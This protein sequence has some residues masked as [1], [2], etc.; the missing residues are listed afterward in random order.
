[1]A[2]DLIAAEARQGRT[3][4]VAS[5]GHM[6]SYYVGR[7]EDAV[8]AQNIE[9]HGSLA[10]QVQTFADRSA[11][12][13]LVLRLGYSG[14]HED[15]SG[16]FDRKRQRIILVTGENPRPEF[17]ALPARLAVSIDLGYAFGD[18]C[19]AI[20]GYPLRVLPSSGVIQTAAY[21]TINVEVLARL[22]LA[23]GRPAAQ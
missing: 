20:E 13:A 19:V 18:A 9:A 17:S 2:A 14:L 5:A 11:D 21:E 6:A 1:V 10:S 12:E 16:V 7:D 15:L 4:K 8:W 3:I 23:G 22:R